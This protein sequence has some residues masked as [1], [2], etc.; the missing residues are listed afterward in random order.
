MA[1]VGQF[2]A[3]VVGVVAVGDIEV[4]VARAASVKFTA[5]QVA[6]QAQVPQAAFAVSQVQHG[7]G[8]GAGE[9][10]VGLGPQPH[11]S[12]VFGD[13]G[14]GQV[15]EVGEAA[16]VG[17]ELEVDAVAV[18]VQADLAAQRALGGQAVVADLDRTGGHVQAAG[19]QLLL[20]WRTLGAIDAQAQ[21]DGVGHLPDRGGRQA[22]CIELSRRLC[23]GRVQVDPVVTRAQFERDRIEVALLHHEQAPAVGHGSRDE[24]FLSGGLEVDLAQL[25]AEGT[26]PATERL[27]YRLQARVMAGAG[28]TRADLAAFQLDML[29][30]ADR[31]VQFQAFQERQRRDHAGLQLH[32]VLGH[33]DA[34]IAVLLVMVV[35]IVVMIII[36]AGVDVGTGGD[37]V[38]AV[39]G[40]GGQ[41]EMA[42]FAQPG[43]AHSTGPGAQRAVLQAAADRVMVIL[44]AGVVMVVVRERGLAGD[45]VVA[46]VAQQAIDVDHP[47]SVDPVEAEHAGALVVDGVAADLGAAAQRR[48]GQV[49][50]DAAVDDID[51]A[52]DR[53]AAEQQGGRALEY[54]DLVGEEGLHAGGV[55]GADRGGIHGAQPG[56]QYLHARAVQAAQD[57]PADAGAEVRGLHAGQLLHGLAQGRGLGPVQGFVAKHLDRPRQRF[58]IAGQRRGGDLDGVQFGRVVRGG[59]QRRGRA[60]QGKGEGPGASEGAAGGEMHVRQGVR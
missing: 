18:C 26:A 3:V 25:Q 7:L 39:P 59:G 33:V 6:E 20:G 48:F 19:V 21:V 58:G 23:I 57:R 14:V 43:R 32:P 42:T 4:D 10:R 54:F 27:L 36:V 47:V 15:D 2:D 13:A 44:M 60:G 49:A 55:V 40:A 5:Y 38:V 17:G 34:H 30:V 51:R 9:H 41:A 24:G 46:G 16:A 37:A 1:F 22:G 12:T 35:V 45:S 8:L 50:G 52:T 31:A 53:T 28:E 56:G 29:V 11:R